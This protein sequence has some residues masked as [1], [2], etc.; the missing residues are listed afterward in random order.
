MALKTKDK[1]LQEE[2]VPGNGFLDRLNEFGERHAKAIIS[3]STLLVILTV[4]LFANVLYERTLYDRVEHDLQ[5]ALGEPTPTLITEKLQAAKKKYAG[6]RGEP[7]ILLALGHHF[8]SQHQIEDAEAVYDDF[9]KR[10]PD[11]PLRQP[12]E[13]SLSVIRENREFD[14]SKKD[15]IL[16][17]PL[18]DVNPLTSAK[19]QKHPQRGSP[20]KEP[21]PVVELRVKDRKPPVRIELFED[22]APNAVAN[23]IALCEEGYF[24][25]LTFKKPDEKRLQINVKTEGAKTFA[26][27]F[28]KTFRPGDYGSLVMVR[29]PDGQNSG[30]EFQILLQSDDELQDATVFGQIFIDQQEMMNSARAILPDKET[31]EALK[32]DSK[33]DHKYEPVRIDGPK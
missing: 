11:H 6:S 33:R 18:L 22:E 32:V 8:V 3:V 2:P 31:I 30:V 26:I 15:A 29:R 21:H 17:A 9:L 16:K 27:A 25:G 10:F 4:V 12:V 19:V 28:E 24:N 20:V 1:V 5:Q 23:F 14:Q 13:R 7:R